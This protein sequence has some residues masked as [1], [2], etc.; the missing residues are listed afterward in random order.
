VSWI[1]SRRRHPAAGYAIL[2]LGLLLVGALYA[3]ITGGGGVATA[4]PPAP[5]DSAQITQGRAIFL[6]D[7]AT[8]HGMG[9]QGNNGVAPGLIG[10][11]A[12]AVDFQVSTGRM[13]LRENDAEAARKPPQLNKSQTHAVAAYIASLGGGPAIPSAAQVSTSGADVGLGQQIF[14]ADCAQCHNFVGA[15]GALTY[16]KY[17]P[18]LTQATPTQIYEAML[19]GPEAMPDFND[20]TLTPGQKRD[21]IAYVTGVR[22]ETNPG[23]FSLGRVGPITEGLVAFL[24]LLLFM[25]LMALW[26]TAKHGKTRT[27]E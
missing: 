21:V 20:A 23:G 27:N 6:Q 15:G 19:T 13:P 7:C 11:G 12:A 2:L 9:A 5:A 3:S 1:T 16:G 26:I 8:C 4:A 25:V 14:V 24:G 17:A 10:V 18:A 22:S